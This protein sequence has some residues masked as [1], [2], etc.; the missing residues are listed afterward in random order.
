MIPL[1]YIA[2]PSYSGSTLLTMLLNAHPELAT[3]GELKWGEIDLDTYRCSCGDL[4]CECRLWDAVEADLHAAGLPFNRARPMTDFRCRQH[5]WTDRVV[6][7]RVRGPLF[8]MAR[9]AIVAS[10]PAPQRSWPRVREVNRAIIE[11][12]MRHQ[13][14]SMFVDA[15]KDPVRLSYLT[16]T[17]DYSVFV[18]QLV[19]DGRGVLNSSLKHATDSVEFATR[20]WR[21]T[22]EQIDR[23]A[24]RLGESR[25]LV[26]RYE[27]L[28]ADPP[29]V[30]HRIYRFLGVQPLG[31]LPDFRAV[32]HHVLGNRM[33]MRTT[34]E[35][36]LDEAWRESLPPEALELFLR[37]AGLRNRMY[38]YV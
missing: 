34:T 31:Y 26:V 14:G 27:D 4:L 36:R 25:R 19:R 30:L 32:E 23:T 8:E 6:R 3:I 24:E 15:S 1:A 9:D 37:I 29:A 21:N 16:Q 17:G 28:C 35:I 33:R 7:S 18:L 20:E 13:G 2:S 10:L 12:V 22:H 11:S 38:G 5:H